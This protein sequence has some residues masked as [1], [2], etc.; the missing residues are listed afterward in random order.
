MIVLQKYGDGDMMDDKDSTGSDMLVPAGVPVF[1]N[2]L[3]HFLDSKA[4]TLGMSVLVCICR[5]HTRQGNVRE[6]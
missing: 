4:P 6:I 1:Q 5:V 2:L 3:L